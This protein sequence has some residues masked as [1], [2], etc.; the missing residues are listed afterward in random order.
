M[1]LF[2]NHILVAWD[3]YNAFN[4]YERAHV[5]ALCQRDPELH[6]LCRL[7]E[8]EFRPR[9]HIYALVKGKLTLLGYRSIQGGQQGATTA[10]MG[11]NIVTLGPFSEVNNAVQ[12]NG[13]CARAIMDDLAVAGDPR[14]VWPAL[15]A[16]EDRLREGARLK[17]SPKPRANLVFSMSGQ[18]GDMPLG[19]SVGTN[20]GGTTGRELGYGVVLAG[21]PVGD[22]IFVCNHV[23]AEAVRVCGV[24]ETTNS[25]LRTCQ[26]VRDHAFSVDRLSLG[27]R[28]DHLT[29]VV[30]PNVPG[31]LEILEGVDQAR[32][33]ALSS[34]IGID[35]RE[36][37]LEGLDPTFT[38]DRSHLP[39]REKGLG[40]VRSADV[41]RSAFVGAMEMAVPRF[42]D[43]VG[44]GG[45]LVAGLF[46]HL[47][48][49]TGS[50]F[51]ELRGRWTVLI[52]SGLPLGAAYTE[53]WENMRLECNNSGVFEPPAADSPGT[54]HEGDEPNHPD[55]RVRLQRLCTR[56]RYR[57]RA[58]ALAARARLLPDGDMR[59]VALSYANESKCLFATLPQESNACSQHEFPGAIAVYLGLPDPLVVAVARTLGP[60][61]YFR[62]AQALRTLDVYGN[63][64]S[65]YMGVGH[66]RTAFHNEVQN[67]LFFLAQA[68]GLSIQRTPVELFTAAVTLQA[69]E[70]YR[71][72]LRAFVQ[73]RHS[74]F[75]GGVVPDL[76]EPLTRQMHDVKTTGFRPEFYEAGLSN[77]NAKEATV[78]ASY[79]KRAEAADSAFN[80]TPPG[81][82]G[83]IAALMATMPEVSC[84]SVGALGE[85]N[86]ATA[87]FLA[88]LADLGSENPER[89]GCCH[90]KEQARGVVASFLG[91]SLGRTLLR[92]V[93]RVRHA[94]LKASVGL[95]DG[96]P[97]ARACNG[98]RPTGNEFDAGF[99]PFVHPNVG[100]P[101]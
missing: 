20:G 60:N 83:P 46:P 88:R 93:V 58:S 74:R 100:S 90:G 85:T 6:D 63:N 19:Y 77:V 25:L 45:Q 44:E 41:A 84:F 33:M 86:R 12:S 30:P 42:A 39:V 57:V 9:S 4:E 29:Q 2:P 16:L 80:D 95:G 11:C 65:L 7:F 61:P 3:I 10:V 69:R 78:P 72:N 101:F 96:A 59:K 5:L 79:R 40:L 68:V 71:G 37:P 97:A 55:T 50:A 98:R 28:L 64:L 48:D 89:F 34:T 91:R 15:A 17:R 38:R 47:A 62:D 14:D 67:E 36:V 8:S 49:V 70:R 76:Y 53:A 87:S 18:Y 22:D 92:G 26:N 43:H 51:G 52:N 99:R 73:T 81:T 56:Q 31:V 23:A 66:G 13:G 94:A 82:V 32:F 1:Q 21:V 27:H 75:A 54:P 24:I 35:P